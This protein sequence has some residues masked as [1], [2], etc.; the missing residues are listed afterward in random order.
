MATIEILN[1]P[2]EIRNSI[3]R[4]V[5]L[6][7]SDVYLYKY[8]SS[9]GRKTRSRPGLAILSTNRQINQEATAVLYSKATFH[10]QTGFDFI[11]FMSDAINRDMTIALPTAHSHPSRHLIRHLHLAFVPERLTEENLRARAKTNW[12]DPVFQE[13]S[14]VQRHTEIHDSEVEETWQAWRTAAKAAE[15][16]AGLGLKTLMLDV[17]QAFCPHGCCRLL[18]ELAQL[19]EWLAKAE[20]V[21]FEVKGL[22]TPGEDDIFREASLA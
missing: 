5:L 1:F 11:T 12:E 7:E 22:N 21:E 3:Y 20:G 16:L 14:R 10:L 13:M 6:P 15:V 18:E 9:R 8:A 19:F 17:E 2:W 4:F